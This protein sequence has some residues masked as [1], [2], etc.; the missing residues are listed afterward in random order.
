[1]KTEK[2]GEQKEKHG[3]NVRIT[4][5]IRRHGAKTPEGE[6]SS[7]GALMAQHQGLDWKDT[8]P[9]IRAYASLFRRAN[10]T[11][12]NLLEGIEV[13]DDAKLHPLLKRG[14]KN[15]LTPPDWK[16]FD[17]L[18][19]N[20]KK[21][22]AE[23]GE[24][25]MVRYLLN[26]PTA[27]EDL[28]NWSAALAGMIDH[29]RR[30]SDRLYDDTNIRTLN[31]AHDVLIADF[32]K[33]VLVVRDG[34]NNRINTDSSDALDKFF[35]TIGGPINY[36]EGFDFKIYSP[37]KGAEKTIKIILRGKEYDVD[38]S[39]FNDLVQKANLNLHKGRGDKQDWRQEK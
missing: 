24:H 34:D 1:M 20:L 26:E 4:L 35:D 28:E 2:L 39:K 6:L 11:L 17:E 29:Y 31:I 32:L 15:E 37:Q 13:Q 7:E 9:T 22:K 10:D 38:E 25:G 18:R 8:E 3:E 16:N 19:V 27:A 14:Q 30:L 33:K 12:N 21:A 23:G 5:S 36:L